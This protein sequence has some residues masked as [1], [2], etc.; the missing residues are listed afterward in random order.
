MADNPLLAAWPGPFEVPPFGHIAPAHFRPAFD[1]AMAEQRAALAGV[2]AD[3]ERPSFDNTIAA[4]E[5]SGRALARVE[6]VF[7]LVAGAD[8]DDAIMAIEREVAP[9]SAAHRN[10]IFTDAALFR[11]VDDLHARRRDLALTAEQARVLE[12]YHLAFRRAGAGLDEAGKT[13]LA[14]IVE[15]LAALGA[16]FGQNVLADEQDYALPLEPEDLAG[17]PEFVRASAKRAAGERGREGHALTLGR[18]SVEPFLQFSARRDLREKLF[19]AWIARGDG[20]AHDNNGLIAEIIAL[21]AE[22]A[23]LLGYANFAD[24][25]LEDA[26]AKTPAA[27]RGLL[28][29]VWSAARPRALAERDALQS[30]VH[31]EGGNFRL[32]PWDWRYYAEKLRKVRHDLD[33]ADLKPYLALDNIIEAAFFTANRL[34]GLT[35]LPRSDVPVWRPEVRVWEVR[36]PRGHVGLFFG[37]YFARAT[38]RSGAWMTS[39]REQEKLSGEVRP[40]IVNVMNFSKAPDGEPTLL[41]FDDAR[42]LFHEFGHALH[43]LL[44]DV[45]YP[46]IAGTNVARD[47]VE[48]PS[49]LYEHWLARPEILR[50]F[51][52]HHRT[53]EPMPEDLMARLIAARNFNQGF[54][55]SEYLGSAFVDLDFHDGREGVVDVGAVEAATRAR[56][57]MPEEIVLRHRPPHF[58]HVFSGEGGYAAGYYDYLWSEVLDADAFAAFEATGDV[59]DPALARRLHD[60]VYAAGNSRDPAEAYRAFRGTL[61]GA[62]ALLRKRGLLQAEST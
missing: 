18:S 24:Y 59:F 33:E 29:T 28:D 25:A 11:R 37:D 31:A 42:T 60:Y 48:L 22:R 58:Q 43:G 15:R 34:F 56:M 16:A 32:A 57:G 45:T 13:R 47:F 8:A 2:A 51:A 12:R 53:G 7:W 4:M 36:G 10:T 3:P 5:R 17:L 35:F 52:R 9:L 21:R 41:S 6:S 61:P 19:A 30:M 1:H 39:I 23:R 55:T 44:S 49:Q 27:A 46:M 54:M 26:M 62:D 40:L 20:G 50:R 14:Q 38:K